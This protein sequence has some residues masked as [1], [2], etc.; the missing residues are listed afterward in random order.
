MNPA[1]E[2]KRLMRDIDALE[3]QASNARQHKGPIH[4]RCLVDIE[5][6]KRRLWELLPT[7]IELAERA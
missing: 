4:R 2:A 7:L 5:E 3:S 6:H 1:A